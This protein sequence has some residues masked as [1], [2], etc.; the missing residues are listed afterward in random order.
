MCVYINCAH[1]QC[2]PLQLRSRAVSGRTVIHPHGNVGYPFVAKGNLLLCRSIMLLLVAASRGC[3]F[4]LEQPG[5]SCLSLHPRWQWFVDRVSV[6]L[7]HLR[8]L[9]LQAFRVVGGGGFES[10]RG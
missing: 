8:I 9:E 10:E 1:G 7:L 3:R 5:Q 6:A 4:L 2:V